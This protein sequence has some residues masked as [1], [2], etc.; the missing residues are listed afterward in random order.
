MSI[1][2]RE[3]PVANLYSVAS[4]RIIQYTDGKK[5]S[6]VMI[7]TPIPREERVPTS[8]ERLGTSKYSIFA[9]SA[10]L[11]A[12]R[13]KSGVVKIHDKTLSN[14]TFAKTESNMFFSYKMSKGGEVK[15]YT[16]KVTPTSEGTYEYELGRTHASSDI[17]ASVIIGLIGGMQLGYFDKDPAEIKVGSFCDDVY[18]NF[19]A[20]SASFA[21][22]AA[23]RITPV[24]EVVADTEY[25][26]SMPDSAGDDIVAPEKK[27]AK[28]APAKKKRDGSLKYMTSNEVWKKCVKGDFVIPPEKANWAPE[29]LQ[30][31]KPLS[32][33]NNYIPDETF[34][35]IVK[36][37]KMKLD[38]ILKRMEEGLT[39]ID[40]IGDDACQ[41]ALVGPPSTGKSYMTEALAA[42]FGLPY[43]EKTVGP[44]TTTDIT[45]GS[46]RVVGSELTF[47]RAPLGLAGLYGGIGLADEFSRG[48]QSQMN[49]VMAAFAERPYHYYE[50][51]C[52]EIIR[53][54]LCVL[55]IAYNAN[56]ENTNPI[57]APIATRF[58]DAYELVLPTKKKFIEMMNNYSEANDYAPYDKAELLEWVWEAYSRVQTYLKK[59][60]GGKEGIDYICP[61]NC[62]AF[63]DKIAA[64]QPLKKAFEVFR[65]PLVGVLKDTVVDGLKDV[66]SGLPNLRETE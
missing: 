17:T 30:N 48:D 3:I 26:I 35:D 8:T 38:R 52:T 46:T 41:I 59:T 49:T 12:N 15:D 25:G 5:T 19:I 18:Y 28:K 61:R 23:K 54:P 21:S 6:N 31:I 27:T 66:Y 24:Y 10:F 55:I 9:I 36:I 13:D 58:S 1:T 45:E 22:S 63:L 34:T 2:R 11:I 60:R 65:T 56:M 14:L 44:D 40:A 29:A 32:F 47:M 51:G 50:N 39:G 43:Y 53:H 64:G 33:L 4:G 16:V 42:V 62:R 57:D 37:M 7:G 20:N